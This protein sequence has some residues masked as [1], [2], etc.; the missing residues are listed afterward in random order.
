MERISPDFTT[1]V[2]LV[3]C[4]DGGSGGEEAEADTYFKIVVEGMR[5][6]LSHHSGFAALRTQITVLLPPLY[7]FSC[8]GLLMKHWWRDHSSLQM[9]GG[10]NRSNIFDGL[11]IGLS[12]STVQQLGA[13]PE[14]WANE[15]WQIAVLLNASENHDSAFGS[16]NPDP[17]DSDLTGKRN[18]RMREGL[19]EIDEAMRSCSSS[20]FWRSSSV[21]TEMSESRPSSGS[22][23]LNFPPGIKENTGIY[24]SS[25]GRD[26]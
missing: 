15:S 22:W 17:S 12:G 26:A 5:L 24:K 20:M 14:T 21:V 3:F 4:Y 10:Q 2:L 23:L 1:V 6:G 13:I 16:R 11:A 8:Q 19:G 25:R 7:M 18:N 9:Q